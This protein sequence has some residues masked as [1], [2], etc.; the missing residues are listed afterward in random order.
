MI[1]SRVMHIGNWLW[2]WKSATM[3]VIEYLHVLQ[4]YDVVDN[5]WFKRSG[6]ANRFLETLDKKAYSRRPRVGRHSWAYSRK[7]PSQPQIPCFLSFK[8]EYTCRGL[9]QCYSTTGCRSRAVCHS[10]EAL[11][12]GR[13]RVGCILVR[14]GRATAHWFVGLCRTGRVWAVH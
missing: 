5:Y 8:Y 12:R 11:H 13:R 14:V 6:R 9:A 7:S 4:F 3:V 10:C 1:S 2:V